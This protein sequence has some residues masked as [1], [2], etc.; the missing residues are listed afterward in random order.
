MVHVAVRSVAV[1]DEGVATGLGHQHEGEIL[2]RHGGFLRQHVV[3]A[4]DAR[5]HAAC[6]VGFVGRIDGRRVIAM[7]MEVN[8]GVVC[9]ADV[10]GDLLHARLDQVEHLDREGAHRALQ[11]AGIGNHVAGLAAVDHRDRDQAGVGRLLAARQD[12]LERQHHF[13]G[14]RHRVDARVRQCGMATLATHGDLELVARCHGRA[15]AHGELPDLHAGPVVHA[16]YCVHREL[17]EQAVLDHLARAAAALFGRLEDQVHGTVE[18]AVFRH[19]LGGRQQHRRVAVVAAG[20]HLSLVDAGMR[21]GVDLGHGQRVH[22]GAQADGTGTGAVFQDADDARS[23]HSPVYRNAPLGE[24]GSHHV[25]GAHFLEAQFRMGM[26]VTS[27]QGNAGCLG[28]EGVDEFHA[29]QSRR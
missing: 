1:A 9:G 18:V 29:E 2:G 26:N 4:D 14:D 25:G 28:D 5:H 3:R 15:G 23:A 21:E 27:H 8:F 17:L 24:L 7:E 16:E 12:G 20:V 11:F 13:A 6:E 19:V 10:L 22:V